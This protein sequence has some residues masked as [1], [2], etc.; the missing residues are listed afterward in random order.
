MMDKV[1][2]YAEV[3]A[4]KTELES[5]L[6]AV[7]K[8]LAD[9]EPDVLDFFSEYG[10]QSQNIGGFTLYINSKVWVSVKEEGFDA[11]RA[12]GLESYIEPKVNGNRISAHVREYM[13]LHDIDDIDDLPEWMRE[14]MTIS[15]VTKVGA[16]KS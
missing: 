1:K 2:R 3:L 12:N 4:E 16:R 10:V 7:K 15:R 6:K 13:A 8:E 14:S 9:L 11:L 5:K